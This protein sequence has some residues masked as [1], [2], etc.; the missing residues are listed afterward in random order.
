M[1]TIATSITCG[2]FSLLIAFQNFA[3]LLA[4]EDDFKH[5]PD[6]REDSHNCNAVKTKDYN[7]V[8]SFIRALDTVRINTPYEPNVAGKGRIRIDKGTSADKIAYAKGTCKEKLEQQGCSLCLQEAQISMW[9]KCVYSLKGSSRMGPRTL[10][11][12]PGDVPIPKGARV[13]LKDCTLR[14]EF[15]KF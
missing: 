7:E 2:L 12:A 13:A 1:G 15:Y 3:L 10:A 9:I 11:Q 4:V 8:A 14:C 5:L 6:F